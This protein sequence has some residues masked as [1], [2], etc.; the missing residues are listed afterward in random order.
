MEVVILKQEIAREQRRNDDE[1]SNRN[2]D[3]V[4]G[5]SGSGYLQARTSTGGGGKMISVM[6]MMAQITDGGGDPDAGTSMGDVK[7]R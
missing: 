5:Q 4:K 1:S 2:V 6:Q 3:D 7:K